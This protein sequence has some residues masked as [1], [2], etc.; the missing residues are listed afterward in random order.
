MFSD[1][2]VELLG[3]AEV[4]VIV[5]IFTRIIFAV[6]FSIILGVERANK[7]HAAGLRTFIIVALTG[8]ISG[9]IDSFLIS[10]YN[11]AIA[12]VSV[13][14]G[15]GIAIISSNTPIYSSKNQLKGLT[16][17]VSLWSS[18]FVGVAFGFGLYTIGT[19][20]S[21]ILIICLSVL[22]S[23]EKY[24]KNRSSHFE[25]QLELKAKTDLPEF[26]AVIRQLGL[27]IDDIESNPAYL[28]SGL[29]VY[30]VSLSIFKKELK[31]YKTHIEIIEALSSLPYINFIEE[32]S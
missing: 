5:Q 30:T 26:V 29:S 13:A 3:L 24:L 11:V 28:N 17:A 21:I 4:P 18:G 19:T 16:T 20:A 7:R 9:L 6:V 31:K 1:P 25:I 14:L 22:P 2:I 12:G 15:I 23:L 27:N 10:K 32:L 8:T